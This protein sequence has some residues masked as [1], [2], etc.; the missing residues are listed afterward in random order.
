MQ[1]AI[2]ATV[3]A[4]LA[5]P[6]LLESPLNYLKGAFDLG[7]VFLFKWTVNW[8]FL[9][10]EVFVHRGFHA[11]LLAAHVIVLLV[12]M[13]KWWRMLRSY[14]TLRRHDAGPPSAVQLLLLPLFMSNFIGIA[15][16]RSL[17]YQ[18]HIH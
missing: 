17:H 8:R 2:C 12:A 7:R 10:E 5:L 14:A 15:F 16:A 1:L 13:P 9:P 11:A 3:Q 18:E 6:F 4:V